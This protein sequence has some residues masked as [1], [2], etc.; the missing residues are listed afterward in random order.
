MIRFSLRPLVRAVALLAIGAVVLGT[1]ADAFAAPSPDHF[2][3]FNAVNNTGGASNNGRFSAW[4]QALPNLPAAPLA[5]LPTF[6]SCFWSNS[7][8]STT[9][10][11]WRHLTWTGQSPVASLASCWFGIRVR[12]VPVGT[13]YF[14]S[15]WFRYNAVSGTP[16]API[17]LGFRISSPPE[18]FNPPTDPT[19]GANT[20]NMVVRNL[21]LAN[22][23]YP[24][25]IDSLRGDNATVLARFAES[26]D[27]PRP[28][29]I[30][31][32]P[33]N[34]QGL[35]PHPSILDP[36][37]C[38]R[39]ILVRG[40]TEDANGQQVSFVTQFYIPLFLPG[41]SQIG[42]LILALLLATLGTVYLVR[43]RALS[44]RFS[45]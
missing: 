12:V 15:A 35:S 29:P 5:I 32:T 2:Y 21:Q 38:S 16:G 11:F 41:T 44:R 31:V 40:T 34:T 28:G 36:L 10:F 14:S 39:V 45:A 17:P 18:L 25:A 23:P 3:S 19:G 42:L 26:L 30:T 22:S 8:V 37:P 43:S 1:A 20:L 13:T 24:I 7:P 9:G 4:G 27:S 6:S 33:G